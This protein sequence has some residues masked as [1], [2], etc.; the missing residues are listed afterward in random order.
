[1]WHFRQIAQLLARHWL[2]TRRIHPSLAPMQLLVAV[3]P[4]PAQV[5]PV[6]C[7][8]RP[9]R[10][11]DTTGRCH[12]HNYVLVH[13]LLVHEALAVGEEPTTM[14]PLDATTSK[15]LCTGGQGREGVRV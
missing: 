1:M 12:S 10:V 9:L 11:D 3:H 5:A 7:L 15:M 8:R 13:A 4:L 6:H 14:L 2:A